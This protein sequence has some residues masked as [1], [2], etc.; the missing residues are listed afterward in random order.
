[1]CPRRNGPLGPNLR[2]DR[3]SDHLIVGTAPKE[4]I[5]YDD[6]NE[7]WFGR[8]EDVGSIRAVMLQR[9]SRKVKEDYP[10]SK[11][12]LYV[13]EDQDPGFDEGYVSSDVRFTLNGGELVL[14]I[15]VFVDEYI[16]DEAVLKTRLEEIVRP[17]LVR[18][19]LRDR[20]RRTA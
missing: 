12:G 16:D 4:V 11:C 1:M 13:V 8:I 6:G 17:L 2:L 15:V 7:Q 14:E 3:E 10:S 20:G 19:R 5:V 18:A 9:V